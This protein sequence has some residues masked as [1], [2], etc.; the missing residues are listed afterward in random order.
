MIAEE[1]E[2]AIDD[3]LP[4]GCGG[5]GRSLPQ[6]GTQCP[7]CQAWPD[8]TREEQAAVLSAPGELTL[9]RADAAERRALDLLQ[10]F[11]AAAAVPDRLRK[12]AEIEQI[13]VEVQEALAGASEDHGVAS[14]RLTEA[15][16]AE[17]EAKAPLDTCLEL[18]QGHRADLEDAERRLL[19]PEAEIQARIAI[20][21]TE[22]VLEK[23]QRLYDQ[24]AA[25]TAAARLDVE[26]AELLISLAEQARDEQAARLLHIEE[27]RPTA[28][29]LALLAHPLVRYAAELAED[30]QSG[31]PQFPDEWANLLG[32]VHALAGAAGLLAMAEEGATAGVLQ[33]LTGP[34]SRAGDVVAMQRQ[35]AGSRLS[36]PPAPGE[37]SMMTVRNQLH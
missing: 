27:V 15:L 24:A 21:Q 17:A 20:A 19:G 26:Q 18:Y 5:C 10:G 32:V 2:R 14:G 25:V 22:P 37:A 35:I 8:I 9:Y 16:A 3:T 12:Q 7:S 1:L 34:L 28:R 4:S 6:P 13:Q 29:G 31:N 23:Y 30:Q 33:E 36:L 11:M